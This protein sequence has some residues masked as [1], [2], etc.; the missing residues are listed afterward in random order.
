MKNQLDQLKEMTIVVADTGDFESLKAYH[1]T[2]STTNPSLILA[3]TEQEQ[4]KHLLDEAIGYGKKKGGSHPLYHILD[5]VFVNFGLEILKIVPGRVSTEVDARYSFDVEGSIQKAKNIISLY[6][7]AGIDRGR[8]LIKLASTWE[9][10]LAAKRLEKEGIHCNMTLLFSLP[11]AIACA[12][13]KATLISPFVGR[14]LDWYKKAEKKEYYPPA[15]DPGVK[16]VTT[17]YH[18]YKKFDYTT[19]IMGASFRNKEEILELAGCDLLTI[20]PP[21]LEELKGNTSLVSRKL[22]PV[23]AK[24]S[25]IEKIKIDEMAFRYLINDDAMATEKLAE[26]IRKF[27]HDI[28]K[29]EK[30]IRVQL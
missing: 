7:R 1:P 24:A 29:L 3:A 5:K 18:Y 6:E 10:V 8:I 23:K 27:A 14:I 19:Q 22:E 4:Y 11:Q 12:E 28:I 16:S 20:A 26:G 2:D 21:L 17:I 25:P 15:E 13:A 9:G 30:R